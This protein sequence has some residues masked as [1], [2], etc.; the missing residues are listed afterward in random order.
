MDRI[1][2][3]FHR[4]RPFLDLFGY[5]NAASHAMLLGM[6]LL[7]DASLLTPLLVGTP[8]I[9]ND[10]GDLGSWDLQSRTQFYAGDLTLVRPLPRR[11]Y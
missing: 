7:T 2:R 10:T 5:R 4:R 1:H 8:V 6:R 11:P 3:M 9:A